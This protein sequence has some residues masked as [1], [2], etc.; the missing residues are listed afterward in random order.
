MDNFLGIPVKVDRSS[1]RYFIAEARGIWPCKRIVVSPHFLLMHPNHQ[2]AVIAHEA[3]HCKNLHMEKRILA[4]P[5]LFLVPAWIQEFTHDQEMEADE[6]AARAGYGLDLAEML[7]RHTFGESQF[8]PSNATR[9][10][11]LRELCNE[12][13]H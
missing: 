3:G 8:Y 11:R 13:A 12:M 4:L 1:K 6:F 9:S 10:S 7:D 5:F 2:R